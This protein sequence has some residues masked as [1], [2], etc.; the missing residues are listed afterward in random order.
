MPGQA[1]K[2]EDWCLKPGSLLPPHSPLI[3]LSKLSMPICEMG[4]MA[5]FICPARITEIKRDD[6]GTLWPQINTRWH[7]HNNMMTVWL[8]GELFLHL[9][10]EKAFGGFQIPL[11]PACSS[12]EGDPENLAEKRGTG[13]RSP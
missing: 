3:H 6:V 4:L 1:R 2:P 5:D 7:L 10:S 12:S 13:G 8:Q 9:L 11:G